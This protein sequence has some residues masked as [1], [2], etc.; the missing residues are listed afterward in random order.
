MTPSKAETNKQIVRRYTEDVFVGGDLDAIGETIAPNYVHHSPSAPDV[1]G[2]EA[3]ANLVRAFRSSF[4][5][6]SLTVDDMVAQGDRV[7]TRLRIS[8]VHSGLYDGIP[9]T[10]RRVTLHGMA[11]DR[12]TNGMIAEGWE[13]SDAHDLR[14]QILRDQSNPR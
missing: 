7:A 13:L 1:V 5:D 10:G 6:I 2:I 8:A 12:V 3:M 4:S 14:N 9:A 11:I